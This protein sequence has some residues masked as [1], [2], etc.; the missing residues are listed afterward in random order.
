MPGGLPGGFLIDE[1]PTGRVYMYDVVTGARLGQVAVAVRGGERLVAVHPRGDK[2]YV[3][4]D[5]ARDED[6]TLTVVSLTEFRVLKELIVPRGELCFR[7]ET[8]LA[9][10]P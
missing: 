8:R 1:G 2:A 9:A 3:A 5:A 10:R 7:D 6:M 4:G